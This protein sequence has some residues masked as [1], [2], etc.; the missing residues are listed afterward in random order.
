M[1]LFIV[2]KTDGDFIFT[3]LISYIIYI[4]IYYNIIY[5]LLSISQTNF[6][7]LIEKLLFLLITQSLTKI[8]FS[9]INPHKTEDHMKHLHLHLLLVG[10]HSSSSCSVL[11]LL[12]QAI[13]ESNSLG[14]LRLLYLQ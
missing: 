10:N 8:V 7:N 14:N 6:E 1:Q 2:F 11:L 9:K 3:I 13:Y 12:V 4:I 5:I